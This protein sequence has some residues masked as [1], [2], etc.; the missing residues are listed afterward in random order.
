MVGGMGNWPLG[1]ENNLQRLEKDE[2]SSAGHQ[3]NSWVHFLEQPAHVYSSS[4][5]KNVHCELLGIAQN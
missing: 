4:L 5:Q 1:V 3:F 2:Q